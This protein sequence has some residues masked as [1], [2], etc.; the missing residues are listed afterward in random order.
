MHP[1]TIL[2]TTSTFPRW[3][4]DNVSPFVYDLV[5][6]LSQTDLK[7]IVL[8]PHCKG[9]KTYEKMNHFEIFRFRYL[10]SALE[11][12]AYDGGILPKLNSNKLYYILVP[13][14]FIGQLAA[15][16]RI[17][18]KHNVR[19]I[20]AHWLIPQGFLAALYKKLFN[21][22]IRIICTSHGS[23]LLGLSGKLVQSLIRFTLSAADQLT[24]VSSA[25][26]NKALEFNSKL[27]IQIIPMGIHSHIFNTIPPQENI[28]K[29]YATN[30]PLILFVGRLSQ[31]KGLEYLINA[32]PAVKRVFPQ[33]SLMIIGDGPLKA[34][35]QKLSSELKLS[36]NI[37][38]VGHV[39]HEQLADFYKSADVL[40]GP[41]LREGLG[42]VFAEALACHC[43]VIASDLKSIQDIIKNEATGFTV[44]AADSRKL[45]EKII[46]VLQNKDKVSK[47]TGA[48]QREVFANFDWKIISNRYYSLINT[49][50][51]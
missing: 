5:N 45:A 26:Q 17:V 24:V 9:S 37:I 11:K 1:K 13:F 39:A 46:Y 34:E 2:V 38:W 4:Q 51:T 32:L 27:N 30:R 35:L 22:N 29:K 10:P 16:I 3:S 40:V 31:E 42:L 15:I 12:L 28:Q 6:A 21:R 50:V 49:I 36:N 47:I 8:A 23:D 44:E 41:S 48:G 7:I 33:L 14:F 43:P 25:L 18:K 20:F 19:L